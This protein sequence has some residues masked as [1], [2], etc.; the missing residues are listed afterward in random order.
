MKNNLAVNKSDI[1]RRQFLKIT[2]IGGTAL[3]LAPDSLF[4]A[5]KPIKTD[6]WVIHG[7]D[8][9]RLMRKCL[10]IIQKNGGFGKSINTLAL[11]V[12]AAWERTPEEGA[13]THPTLVGEFIKG[14]RKAGIKK[15][16]VPEHPC[17]DAKRSFV[18]SGILR[19]VEKNGGI[20]LDLGR[21][22]NSFTRVDIPQG[23]NL[24]QAEVAGEFLN[25]DVV[26]NMPVAK[27]HSGAKLTIAMK[28]WMGAVRDRGF[29]HGNNLH[30]CIADFC[31]FMKPAWTIVDATR[32]MMDNGPQGPSKNVRRPD[33]LIISKDQVAADAYAATLFPTLK[34]QALYIKLA[35]EMGIG[36]AD[37]SK[38]NI[39]KIS[40]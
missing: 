6:V 35:A 34:D 29:W 1:S 26:V 4:S 33:L 11:K 39:K 25:A 5:E 32:I 20:M 17:H 9:A 3:S 12:N 22:Q 2:V 31:T 36:I 10:E 40:V 27:H 19:E 37:I 24:K 23:K 13:T 38:M 8:K 15:I 30:Q 28:N 21:N 18:K 7:K 14:C 16:L